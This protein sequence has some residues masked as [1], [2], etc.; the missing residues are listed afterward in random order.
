LAAYDRTVSEFLDS[1]MPGDSATVRTAEG[2]LTAAVAAYF[3]LPGAAAGI[4]RS[5]FA[6]RI[7]R[8]IAAGQGLAERSHDRRGWLAS[9][10][11]LLEGIE[12]RIASA[13]GEGFSVG[14]NQIFARRSLAELD[15]AI[16][17]LRAEPDT[18]SGTAGA[19]EHLRAVLAAHQ[20]ELAQSPGPA[21]LELTRDD[22][23]DSAHLRERIE[24]FDTSNGAERRAFL[25]EGAALLA[26][27]QAQL[28]TPARLALAAAAERA[29][30]AAAAAQRTLAITG[31]AVVILVL[32][33][34]GVLG[35]RI[36]LPVRR[37][38]AAT[39]R[40]ASG[41]RDARAG[42]AGLAEIDE[43][44][45]SFNAMAGQIAAVEQQLR[46]HQAELE[47]RV[48]ERTQQLEHLAH[49]D[50]LTALPN[51]RHLSTTLRTAIARAAASQQRFAL[52][53]VD[54]DN[55]K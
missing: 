34:S 48:A 5:D 42:R 43:L 35:L 41:D 6:A 51:R 46:T 45:E 40:L 33:V 31:I 44:A 20:T 4:S 54:L 14:R 53:F 38:T 36:T 27:A 7:A 30:A 12:R 1:G 22:L 49:H 13:G 25:E 28:Q 50:P 55:F 19:E 37:L 32:F 39:R 8:H 52:L 17:Q 23:R 11:R 3:T 2:D 16:N 18:G 29:A 10:R 9:R 24:R 47:Q 26:S 15:E 21:W